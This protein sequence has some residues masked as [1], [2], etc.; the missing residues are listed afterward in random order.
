M[1]EENTDGKSL[2]GT[3]SYPGDSA[4]EYREEDIVAVGKALEGITVQPTDSPRTDLKRDY[5]E[6]VEDERFVNGWRLSTRGEC[7][8]DPVTV[9]NSLGYGTMEVV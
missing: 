2:K 8:S 6:L 3:D 9:W 5:G 7:G 1:P 4:I